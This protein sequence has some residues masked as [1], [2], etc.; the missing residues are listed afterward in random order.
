MLYHNGKS[1]VTYIQTTTNHT[2][3]TILDRKESFTPI[4][5]NQI[6]ENTSLKGGL[7]L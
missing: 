7:D 5:E 6:D 1:F 4:L 2:P 3:F